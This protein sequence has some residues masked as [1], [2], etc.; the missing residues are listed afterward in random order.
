M[1][2]VS[3]DYDSEHFSKNAGQTRLSGRLLCAVYKMLGD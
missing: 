2:I 3:V 1:S